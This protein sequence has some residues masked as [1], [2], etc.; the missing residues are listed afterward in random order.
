MNFDLATLTQIK[1][2]ATRASDE[3]V[4]F[5]S[6]CLFIVNVADTFNSLIARAVI[7]NSYIMTLRCQSMC[8]PDTCSDSPAHTMVVECMD[9]ISKVLVRTIDSDPVSY[10][11]YFLK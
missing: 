10:G 6:P 4:G 1:G 9:V 2:I 3:Y 5:N 8:Y 11:S 7:K